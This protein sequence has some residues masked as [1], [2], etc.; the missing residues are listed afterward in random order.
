MGTNSDYCNVFSLGFY[1]GSALLEPGLVSSFQI[2]LILALISAFVLVLF[3]FYLFKEL[4]S[5][6]ISCFF[7]YKSLIFR[8]NY[9]CFNVIFFYS[10]GERMGDEIQVDCLSDL[11]EVITYW[12]LDLAKIGLDDLTKIGLDDLALETFDE[13]YFTNRFTIVLKLLEIKECLNFPMTFDI[14]SRDIFFKVLYFFVFFT[15]SSIKHLDL[16]LVTLSKIS[17]IFSIAFIFFS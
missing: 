10:S 15:P 4:I 17:P 7:F 6:C 8:S 12:L 9:F 5:C 16:F 11:E 14:L 3:L 1:F 13:I 2:Y